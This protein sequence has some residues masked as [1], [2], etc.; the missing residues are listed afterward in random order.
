MI[1]ERSGKHQFSIR[2]K[3]PE[4]LRMSCNHIGG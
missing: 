1:G 3:L 2:I 4:M